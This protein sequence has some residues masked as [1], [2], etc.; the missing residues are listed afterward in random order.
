MYRAGSASMAYF[1]FDFRDTEKQSRRNLLPSL[2]IQLSAH[3]GPCFD[4]L[5][6]F[7][8][9]HDNGARQP[10]DNA[11]TQCLKEM[12]TLPNHGPIY[13]ILDGLDEC[14]NT[15]EFPSARRQVLYLLKEFADL[16]LPNLHICVTSRP[17]V[18]IKDV[19][20]PLAFHSVSLHDESGQK[21]DIVSYVKSAVYSDTGVAMRR[22]RV[23]EKELVIQTLSDR[24]DGM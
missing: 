22:W 23:E 21:E 5:S 14:P 10:N 20:E 8:E 17:E 4:I 18:D 13:L 9:T 7:Y 24:A 2:L 1:Y 15:S 3:S 16:R 12:I 19:I 11:L 6:R